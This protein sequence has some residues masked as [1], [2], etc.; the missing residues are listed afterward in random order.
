MR[1]L[2]TRVQASHALSARPRLALSIREHGHHDLPLAH[3]PCPLVNAPL[4]TTTLNRTPRR[5]S[6]GEQTAKELNQQGVD[7]ALSEFD[8]AVTEEKEKV[9]RAP[10]HRQGVDVPPVRRQRSAGAMTKGKLLAFLEGVI[11][12]QGEC[13]ETTYN[14][15][16]TVEVSPASDHDRSKR[17]Q[18]GCS[19]ACP[20]RPST[21]A[22]LLPGKVDPG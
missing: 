14:S 17:R 22:T 13:R 16:K 5:Y 3:R 15:V 12:Y 21:A 20:P 6:S 9:T 4:N 1:L 18:K 11:A 8:T 19:S 7:E 10:W 2:L